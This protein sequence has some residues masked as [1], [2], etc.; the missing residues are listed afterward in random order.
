MTNT[1]TVRLLMSFI[2]EQFWNLY[3][4]VALFGILSS[5]YSEITTMLRSGFILSVSGPAALLT[6]LIHPVIQREADHRS[7]PVA[8]VQPAEPILAAGIPTV[9][10]RP[11]VVHISRARPVARQAEP[12]AQG[13]KSAVNEKPALKPR[14]TMREGC[15]GAVSSL[16]GPEARRMVPGRC[17][18]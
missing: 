1:R 8:I 10:D 6:V 9:S 12:E 17:I 11:G 13:V 3:G 7:A 16:A 2:L 5:S 15:E 4:S 14:R 18:A